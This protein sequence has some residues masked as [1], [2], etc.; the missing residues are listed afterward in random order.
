[1][2]DA[3]SKA[4][5]MSANPWSLG[6]LSILMPATSSPGSLDAHWKLRQKLTC[7][8]RV[9]RRA[10]YL[11]VTSQG[12]LRRAVR[13][14]WSG[15]LFQALVLYLPSLP[16]PPL[17]MGLP[18][19]C[20]LNTV[21]APSWPLP[22]SSSILRLMALGSPPTSQVSFT[23][24]Q[25]R[26]IQWPDRPSRWDIR[27]CHYVPHPLLA[28]LESSTLPLQHTKPRSC[29]HADH[30]PTLLLAWHSILKSW[31]LRS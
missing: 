2:L 9:P 26:P 31:S 10:A 7:Q 15:R 21:P 8:T 25:S 19:R 29:P 3:S 22:Q 16:L 30:N 20:T 11:T 17:L 28:C 4:M 23:V 12:P 1:M 27:A 24:L 13:D 14:N 6:A 5:M 18:L